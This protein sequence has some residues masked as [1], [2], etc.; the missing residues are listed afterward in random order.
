M[1]PR[2]GA[3]WPPPHDARH[4]FAGTTSG[5]EWID[6]LGVWALMVQDEIAGGDRVVGHTDW[7]VQNLRFTGSSLSAAYDW[8]SLGM[9]REP[10]LVGLVARG[11]SVDWRSPCVR[12]LPCVEEALGFIGDY[13]AAR[14]KPFSREEHRLA[15]AA[16]VWRMAYSARCEHSDAL[17]DFGRHPPHPGKAADPSP[18]TARAFLAAHAHRLLTVTQS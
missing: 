8:D 17:T 2:E 15:R 7:R 18:G 10:V 12:R 1:V 14:S 3:V 5:A 6:Q 9:E 11:F 13:E 16:L 4:N